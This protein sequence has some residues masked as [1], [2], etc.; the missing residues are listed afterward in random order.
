MDR[1]EIRHKV[2]EYLR[3]QLPLYADPSK[4]PQLQMG[5]LY[6]LF[7]DVIRQGLQQWKIDQLYSVIRETVHELM[8]AGILYPG[9]PGDQNSSYPWLTITEH[10]REALS[11]ENWLPYDPEGYTKELKKRVPEIDEVTFNYIAES[12]SAFHRRQILSA[13][14]TLGVAS[15]NLMLIVIEAYLN[16]MK[17][18]K[19]KERLQKKILDRGIYTQYQ[20]FKQEFSVDVKSF[21]KELK[22]DWETYLDGIFN[23]IRLNRNS[24]GHPTGKG[25]N[26]KIIYANLQIFADYSRYVFDLIKYLS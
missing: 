15:E 13:T 18:P 16:W 9:Q 26:V 17:D 8:N 21:P 12:V 3:Q 1:Q 22:N 10:G 19:R 2:I 14:L 4:R 20:E 7:D 5:S 25:S 23:F 6:H 24:A 11:E